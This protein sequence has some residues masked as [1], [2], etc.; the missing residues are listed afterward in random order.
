MLNV[1]CPVDFTRTSFSYG[2][3]ILQVPGFFNISNQRIGKFVKTFLIGISPDVL[4]PL[5]ARKSDFNLNHSSTFS[6]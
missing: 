6:S 4:A 3:S 2:K 5:L 1:D